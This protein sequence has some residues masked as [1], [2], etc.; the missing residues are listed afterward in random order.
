MTTTRD[1][2]VFV[3]FPGADRPGVRVEELSASG[4]GSPFPNAEWNSWKPG[5]DPVSKFVRVNALRI[6][7]DGML[8]VVNSGAP[9]IG[10]EA[11]KGAARIIRFDLATNAVS[12]I[13]DLSSVAKPKSYVDDIRFN[14]SRAYITDAGE[15]ALIVLDLETGSARRVL[16]NHPSTIDERPM[17]ADGRVL[18]KKDGAE[19]RVPE[20]PSDACRSCE[21]VAYR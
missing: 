5:A 8:W 2:R 20:R 12:R 6:G 11:V 13:Y 7:P 14:G 9:G 19:L 3:G 10:E 16:E 18:R 17:M 4:E 15:P 1:N 21:L